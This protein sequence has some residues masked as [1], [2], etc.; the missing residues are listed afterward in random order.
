MSFTRRTTVDS[1]LLLRPPPLPSEARPTGRRAPPPTRNVDPVEEKGETEEEKAKKEV[2]GGLNIHE[3]GAKAHV[4][5]TS[6]KVEGKWEPA[7]RNAAPHFTV[8][9]FY[10]RGG[11]SFLASTILPRLPFLVLS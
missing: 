6:K 9:P 7:A 10:A 1:P 3:R 2:S 5:N 4:P 8:P 11:D